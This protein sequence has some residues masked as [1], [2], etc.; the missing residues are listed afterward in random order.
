MA[1]VFNVTG[2]CRPDKHYMVNIDRRLAEIRRLVDDGAYFVINRARQYGKTTTLR[3]LNHDL[4]NSYYVILMD[5]QIFGEGEFADENIFSLSFARVFL[6][7]LKRNQLSGQDGLKRAIDHLDDAEKGRYGSFRLQRLFE[8]L[9]D[10][11]AEADKRVVLMIDEVDSASNNQVF[12][13]FL[14]QL[15]AYY[16]DRDEQPALYSVILAGVYD[17]KNLKRKLRPEEEHKINSPWNIAA[18][19]KVDMSFSQEEI[20]GML[21][22]YEADYHT[23]MDISGIAEL[24]YDYTSGYPFLVSDRKSTRLN[25]SH[26]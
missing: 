7:A 18:D 4:K 9:S 26:M 12:L 3:A 21:K 2:A 16:I 25:S 6:R 19:F 8:I 15:R 14:S 10:I 22:E 13:D 1:R 24:I 11:C 5:F 20:A 17:V 23:G